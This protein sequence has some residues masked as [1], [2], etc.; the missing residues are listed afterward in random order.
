MVQT[1]IHHQRDKQMYFWCYSFRSDTIPART[2][3]RKIGWCDQ[4]CWTHS[5]NQVRGLRPLLGGGNKDTCFSRLDVLEW[6]CTKVYEGSDRFTKSRT[7]IRINEMEYLPTPLVVK[8]T[9]LVLA[10][11]DRV[12][13]PLSNRKF[14]LMEFTTRLSLLSYKKI[15]SPQLINILTVKLLIQNWPALSLLRLPIGWSKLK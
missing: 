5:M 12:L 7:A 6:R 3:W 14:S 10:R 13:L 9:S 2:R 1:T 15:L 11:Y 4:R 8:E